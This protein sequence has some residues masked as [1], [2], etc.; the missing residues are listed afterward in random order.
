MMIISNEDLNENTIKC[1]NEL[2]EKDISPTSAFNLLKI[3]TIINDL[4]KSKNKVYSKILDKYGTPDTEDPTKVIIPKEDA[5]QFNKE[6]TELMQMQH[7]VNMDK[8]KIE[9]LNLTE[10]IKTNTLNGIKF[11]F[12]L[13][14]PSVNPVSVENNN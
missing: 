4:I 7:E 6:M 3:T 8:F 2:L 10:N 9:D 5:D 1:I 14:M 11:L 13:D 12:E